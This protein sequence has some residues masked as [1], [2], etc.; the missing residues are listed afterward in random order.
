MRR[1]WRGRRRRSARGRWDGRGFWVGL[2][3]PWMVSAGMIVDWLRWCPL[4][5]GPRGQR[6]WMEDWGRAARCGGPAPRCAR[7]ARR[8]GGP[9]RA[10][11]ATGPQPPR[12]RGSGGGTSPGAIH[13]RPVARHVPREG[14]GGVRAAQPPPAFG[15]DAHRCASWSP[16]PPLTRAPLGDA[17]Q[18]WGAALE[19]L[20]AA[21]RSTGGVD[22]HTRA[23]E[24][25]DVPQYGSFADL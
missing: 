19:Q 16:G 22:G 20:E 8:V 12:L 14:A 25:L 4:P 24:R 13:A 17:G 3:H 18:L 10:A 15:W 9:R 21:A 5:R 7:G 1:A 2:L 6:M 11:R 23:G